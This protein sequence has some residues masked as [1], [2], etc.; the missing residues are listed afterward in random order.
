MVDIGD[1]TRYNAIPDCILN[2]S[3]FEIGARYGEAQLASRH[4][5]TFLSKN[6]IGE[7]I[8]IDI[9]ASDSELTIVQKD[10]LTD[11]LGESQ[12]ATILA[13]AVLEHVCLRQWPKFFNKVRKYLRPGG[14]FYMTVPFNERLER[15]KIYIP[16]FDTES[17]SGHVVYGITEKMIRLFFPDA[18][19]HVEQKHIPIRN[20][21]EKRFKA[22]CR[23]LRRIL[24]G[25][26]AYNDA[27]L[28]FRD[29]VVI[30]KQKE[31]EKEE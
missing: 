25:I 1:I 21:G 14:T 20:D 4:R 6:K 3:I 29:L 28:M 16:T 9:L 11:D 12:Y 27:T 19:C 8:G 15:L 5:A 30:W 31:V 18:E 13:L 17:T 2:G 10:F 26:N 24:H 7:Y 23:F 22:I